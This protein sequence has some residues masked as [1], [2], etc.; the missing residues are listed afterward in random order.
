MRTCR[1]EPPRRAAQ[2]PAARYPA[3]CPVPR[4]QPSHH[5]LLPDRDDKPLVRWITRSAFTSL[6]PAF[7]S[8]GS[9]WLR[10]AIRYPAG[11]FAPVTM[12]DGASAG[13]ERGCG[14][15][16]ELI[17]FLAFGLTSRPDRLTVTVRNRYF[18]L[19]LARGP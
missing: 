18:Q 15:P 9:P 7:G 11:V 16:G 3:G 10:V 12:P 4:R 19:L 17:R 14:E 5:R 2:V 6:F 1:P 13:A 8:A